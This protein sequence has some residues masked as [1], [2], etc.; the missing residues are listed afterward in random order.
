M[1]KIKFLNKNHFKAYLIKY[2]PKEIW[3]PTFSDEIPY[4][5]INR[6]STRTL[7]GAYVGQSL[8][9]HFLSRADELFEEGMYVIED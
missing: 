9:T 5:R 1:K 8:L 2:E 6:Y 3:W 7:A 4:I